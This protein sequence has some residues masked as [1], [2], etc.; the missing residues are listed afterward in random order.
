MKT[1]AYDRIYI[2]GCAA[3]YAEKGW[4]VFPLQG[5]IPLKDSNGLN[6]ATTSRK[7]IREWFEGRND[8]NVGI[9]TGPESNLTIID[10]DCHGEVS[11]F[12]SLS[13]LEDEYGPLLTKS[14][15]TPSGGRH[16]YFKYI[17]GSTNRV[18]VLPGIDVRS[19]GGYVVAPH[20]TNPE[21]K[22]YLWE[23]TLE[24]AEAPKWLVDIIL[25]PTPIQPGEADLDY[26]PIGKRNTT[27]FRVL[28]GLRY[29]GVP[30][31]TARKFAQNYAEDC[32]GGMP[33]DEAQFVVTNVY[34]RY[35]PGV[36]K[37]KRNS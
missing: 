5:K 2:Y 26:I 27:L 31:K 1:M 34:K 17:P 18:G 19:I 8:R 12:D 32:E 28:C 11:G 20:S 21:G 13:Q 24:P 6:D 14:V 7:Q 4:H 23:N 30:E 16:L 22:L 3:A 33:P 25:N 36:Y 37:G 15:K 29:H 10:V 9:R 35:Q